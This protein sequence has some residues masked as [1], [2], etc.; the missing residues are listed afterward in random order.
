[1]A[2]RLI[3]QADNR[4]PYTDHE[5]YYK[6]CVG[7][8]QVYAKKYNADYMF[9]ELKSVPDNRHWS[10]ARILL[11]AKYFPKYD[12]IL[13][14][15]SDATIINHN[16]D[17]FS[18]F[19]TT[20]SSDWI[21]DPTVSPLL[22]ACRDSPNISHACCG[23]LLLDCSNK[24]KV[25]DMLNDWWNDIPND[26]FKQG[27]PYEQSV[28]NDVWRLDKIKRNYVKNVDLQSFFFRSDSQAFIHLTSN[29]YLPTIQL[30]DAKKYAA[31]IMTPKQKKIGLFVRQQNFY[32]SGCGQN[33]IFIKQSLEL[34]GYTVDLL[35]EHYDQVKS[36]FITSDIAI[37]Y[38]DF[39]TIQL[40]DYE[41]FIF[42][43]TTVTQQTLENIRSHKIKTVMFH[44]MN[45][46]D[47]VHI[48]TFVYP[49]KAD[50][51]P[52]FESNF[53]HFGDEVWLTNNHEETAKAYTA[54]LNKCQVP[55][56]PIP[57]SWSPLFV[58]PSK[59]P[60]YYEPR[61]SKEV[62]FVIIEPNMSYC[63]TA[64]FPLMIAEYVNK[65]TKTVKHVHLFN[66]NKENPLVNTLQLAKE[67]KITFKPRTQI[68]EII[69]FFAKRDNHVIF[70]SHQINLPLSY[71]YFD[72]LSS[73]FPFVHNSPKLLEQKQGYYYD[74]L[75]TASAAIQAIMTSFN[76]NDAK[77][78]ANRY[79]ETI[80]PGNT[81]IMKQFSELLVTTPQEPK[82][83]IRLVILTVNK[84]REEFMRK[85]LQHMNIMYPV[86]FF[87]GHTPK[88]SVEYLKTKEE[89]AL[90]DSGTFC[91]TRSYGA[92]FN[93]YKDKQFEYLLTLEDDVLLA[94]DFVQKID[95]ILSLW[96]TEQS[97]EFINIGMLLGFG[98]D[99]LKNSSHKDGL[100]YNEIPSIWGAQAVLFKPETVKSLAKLLH[101]GSIRSLRAELDS[102]KNK[103]LYRNRTLVCQIDSILPTIFKQ[104]MYYPPVAIESTTMMSVRD[105]NKNGTAP[106]L[107]NHPQ[108][109]LDAFYTP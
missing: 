17:V 66:C 51:V 2:K 47:A 26:K 85:Q 16:V 109:H 95:K 19:K 108:I 35:I 93:A 102:Y 22:Y 31:R 27:F 42:G 55:I 54:L 63:K 38:T 70:L 1:M 49:K 77:A 28:V 30:H 72:I 89:N 99:E 21:R 58:A 41:L 71:A 29:Y 96:E 64:W 81:G 33:C 90:E 4:S 75:E 3:L 65:H 74:T 69:S 104:G 91:V 105:G 46:M 59:S 13:W 40:S 45:S 87:Q 60:A 101:H 24:A 103:K 52:L 80:H 9:E 94:K 98:P 97:I 23:I 44:P 56:K 57:L 37:P 73:G 82:Q 32:S 53:K 83:K 88:T 43:T 5:T 34:L 7:L 78:N 39:K 12:E 6:Y 106:L 48:D 11:F 25:K 10:W 62:E 79:L 50:S 84:E 36:K 20:K 14:L 8:A 18:L 15:D 61:Q 86:E 92:L 76:P 107:K 67:N 68:N 100:Y